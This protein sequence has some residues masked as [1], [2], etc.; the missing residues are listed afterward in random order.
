[1]MDTVAYQKKVSDY[2]SAACVQM[3]LQLAKDVGI[4]DI[5]FSA[6]QPLTSVKIAELGKLKERYVREIIGA[7][8]TSEII[9]VDESSTQFHIPDDHK[10]ILRRVTAFGK[11]A[12]CMGQRM[13]QMKD[14]LSKDGPDGMRFDGDLF[15]AFEETRILTQDS[16]LDNDI[17]ACL[18]EVKDRLEKGIDVAEFGCAQGILLLN[19]AARYPKST[20]LGSDISE[21]CVEKART[22]AAERELTN[23]SFE[24][25]DLLDLPETINNSFDWIFLRDTLHDLPSPAK[26]LQGIKQ[27]LREDG[28]ASIVEIGM[29]GKLADVKGDIVWARMFSLSTFLCIPESFQRQS[30]DAFGACWG[31]EK[32]RQL[33]KDAGFTLV[34]EYFS[35]KNTASVNY[36]CQL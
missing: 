28:T 32:A 3:V 13:G 5:L 21:S 4:L 25:Y 26:A 14:I 6:E 11:V 10:A 27:A 18:P 16:I 1:M 36:V 8:A 34:K 9:Q 7:L 20:F 15:G 12:H 29:Q 31:V 35:E 22:L 17:L 24:V 2:F 23:V 33:I 19:L 30:S